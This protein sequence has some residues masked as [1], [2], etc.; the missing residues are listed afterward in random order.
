MKPA[1]LLDVLP[2]EL[3]AGGEA[4][5]HWHVGG[6]ADQRAFQDQSSA[7]DIIGGE[8]PN[9]SNLRL[10]HIEIGRQH[11]LRKVG[12]VVA[13]SR[14]VEV[15]NVADHVI[16]GL[17][18]ISYHGVHYKR[19]RTVLNSESDIALN[20]VASAVVDGTSSG[21]VNGAALGDPY[22]IWLCS[23]DAADATLTTTGAILRCSADRDMHLEGAAITTGG[24]IDER[25]QW[26]SGESTHPRSSEAFSLT[27]VSNT[28]GSRA[29]A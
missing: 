28:N 19:T 26:V 15:L 25:H 1:E 8:G 2:Q 16:G 23:V 20:R 14:Q 7:L 13:Q 17:E 24:I 27:L 18:V 10:R 29:L 9:M 6:D 21:P 3:P 12:R 11:V 22:D 4:S 5:R